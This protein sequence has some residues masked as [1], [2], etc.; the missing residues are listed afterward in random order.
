MKN[1]RKLK[2]HTKYQVR[3]YRAT[4]IPIIKLAGKWLNK[5]GFKEGQM[6]NINQKKNRLII[7]ID[8]D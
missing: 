1:I 5:L 8:K 7:T 3:T 6:I 2:I 4:T